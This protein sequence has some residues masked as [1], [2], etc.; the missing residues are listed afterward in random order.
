MNP[1]SKPVKEKIH[2]LV[3]FGISNTA[4]IKQQVDFFVRK[5]LFPD[6]K[7]DTSD[8]AFN[9]TR[10]DIQ[11]HISLAQKKVLHGD[12]QGLKDMMEDLAR[13]GITFY[14][15]SSDNDDLLIVYKTSWQS[16]LLK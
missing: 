5:E 9:P 14:R 2:E 6:G 11:N 12:Q 7:L 3:N 10:K 15:P 1:L 16:K 4:G 13:D 8:R